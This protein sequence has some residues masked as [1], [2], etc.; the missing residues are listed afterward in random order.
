MPNVEAD[1]DAEARTQSLWDFALRTYARPNVA[2]ICLRLQD[3]FGADVPVL[4]YGAWMALVRG[5][6]LTPA[7]VRETVERVRPWQ[8]EVVRPLRAIRRDLKA[9]PYPAPSPEAEVMR[10]KLK[11]VEIEAERIE[12]EV[13]E[14]SGLAVEARATDAPT[15]QLATANLNRLIS[16]FAAGAPPALD[17]AGDLAQALQGPSPS[18]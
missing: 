13:L 12:L 11:G 7:Q 15:P 2:A 3:E 14:H 18:N 4:L 5:T 16:Y 1:G 6:E 10:T 17:L 8:E 9:G